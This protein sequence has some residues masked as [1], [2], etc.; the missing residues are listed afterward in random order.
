MIVVG[1]VS[2]AGAGIFGFAG[3]PGDGALT[4]ALVNEF[5]GFTGTGTK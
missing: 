1:M 2:L 5:D 4:T 3:N